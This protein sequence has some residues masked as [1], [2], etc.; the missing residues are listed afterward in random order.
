VAADIDIPLDDD[1]VDL[2]KLPPPPAWTGRPLDWDDDGL[3][4]AL[5]R[6]A[7]L[8]VDAAMDAP[9]DAAG[10]STRPDLAATMDAVWPRIRAGAANWRDQRAAKLA[11]PHPDAWQLERLKDTAR[12]RA[13]LE[14]YN[15]MRAAQAQELAARRMRLKLQLRVP[16]TLWPASLGAA[17]WPLDHGGFTLLGAGGTLAALGLA[18]WTRGG[19]A[20]AAAASNGAAN[21]DAPVAAS[22]RP[23]LDAATLTEALHAATPL[24]DGDAVTVTKVKP[25]PGNNGWSCWVKLPAYLP[26]RTVMAK[27]HD[28]ATYLDT[29]DPCLIMLPGTSSNRDLYVWL[30]DRPPLSA[31]PT[32]SPMANLRGTVDNWKGIPLGLTIHGEPLV[33]R[34]AGGPG[35]LVAGDP[36]MGKSF[37]SRLLSL[38]V[39]LDPHAQGIWMDPDSSGTWEPFSAVGEYLEGSDYE[40]LLAMVERLEWAA[41]VELP[42]RREALARWRKIA[43]YAVADS[44]ITARIAR[45]RKAGLPLLVI[46]VDE[47]HY[48]VGSAAEGELKRRA[49][50][51]MVKLA[52]AG[53]KWAVV[54]V[55]Q[56]QYATDPNLPV[57]IRNVL[58]TRLC[59]SVATEGSARIALG[60]IYDSTAMDPVAL[61]SDE[62]GAFYMHGEGL[63]APS[64]PWVLARGDLVDDNEVPA[65]L[66]RAVELRQQRRP[67]LL[68]QH[69]GTVTAVLERPADLEPIAHLRNLVTCFREGEDALRS[70]VLIERLQE[71][72]P[73]AYAEWTVRGMNTR[74]KPLGLA[75]EGLGRQ[76]HAGLRLRTVEYALARET[77]G[78]PAG[79]D[80]GEPRG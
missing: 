64:A 73:V 10:A 70:A 39:A 65:L 75:T 56:T 34:L 60:D 46:N 4:P 6:T 11:A 24:K 74:L 48:L 79:D 18:A 41:D 20:L 40:S 77:A 47:C 53:R 62:K 9:V 80:A 71:L 25:M 36:G 72:N 7:Q 13:D 61:T 16:A 57:E 78:Q 8:R 76:K 30:A 55:L 37:I 15:A 29:V 21:L 38:G 50:R 1:A 68:P 52:T 58:K 49:I 14:A 63:A 35:W 28:L 32:S 17:W 12:S 43:P 19:R 45:D 42:R 69:A 3:D 22:T 44:K 31:A 2:A 66:E 23:T 27:R 54:L 51:A 33:G 59:L 5:D 67:E 26:A